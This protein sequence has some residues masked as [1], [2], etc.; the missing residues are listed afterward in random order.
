VLLSLLRLEAE[1]VGMQK[2]PL[3]G[4]GRSRSSVAAIIGAAYTIKS[5][6]LPSD[7]SDPATKNSYPSPHPPGPAR[8]PEMGF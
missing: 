2:I 8:P 4:H 1:F 3:I 7:G 6:R 5:E